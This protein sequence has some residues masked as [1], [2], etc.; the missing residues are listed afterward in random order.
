MSL[1]PGTQLGPYEISAPL[2]AGGMGEVYRARDTRLE[3]T[4]AIKILPAQFSSDPVR[5]QRFEREAK[6]I[7]S[8]NHPHICVLHDVGHQDGVDYLVM[9]CVEGETLAKRLEKG[10]LPLEQVLKYGAQI[11][12]ALDK[13]HRKGVVHRDLKPGNMMLTPSGAKLLD[14]GLARPAAPLTSVATMTAAVTQDSPV[15][16]QGTIVGTFQ[17][18][19]PE[20]VEGKEL[21]GR[22]DIFSLGAVLYEMLTGQR[23]FPGKSQLSVASAILEKEPAPISSI[24]P[25]APPV[26]D[27]AVKKCLA[28][29][30]ED[31]W[32]SAHD[33]KDELEW[34]SQTS[35]QA[36]VVHVP[37]RRQFSILVTGVV[38]V[39][40]GA[41]AA[42]IVLWNRQP[43]SLPRP[44]TRFAI[45]LPPRE[46][47]PLVTWPT[48]AS[49]PDGT[50][51][52]Y[53]AGRGE[54]RQL[55][56]RSMDRLE[57]TPLGGTENA[58]SPFFSPDGQW[59]GFFA[60][61]KLKK[62]NLRGGF[63]LTVCDATTDDRGGSWGPDDT[64]IFAPAAT[65]GLMRVPA[66][67]GTPQNLTTPDPGKRER[68]HRWPEILPGGK[69]VVFTIGS[70]DSIDYYLAAKIAVQ[71]LETGKREILPV[72]GTF[73]RYDPAGYIVLAQRGGLFAV[74]FD[75]KR[76]Q[77]TGT[78]LRVLDDVAMDASTGAIDFSL[79][80][81]GSLS[82]LPGGWYNADLVLAWVDRK[83]FVQPLPAPARAYINAHVSPD[84]KRVA[85][86]DQGGAS[87]GIWVYDIPRGTMMRL[88][89]SA[90]RSPLWTPD[91][92]HIAYMV[93]SNRTFA[94]KWKLADGSGPEETLLGAQNYTQ[95]PVSWSPDGKF[96]AYTSVGGPVFSGVR[97]WILPLEGK[98]EPQEFVK[99]GTTTGAARFSPNG[100]WIAYGSNE[101]GRSEVYVEPFPGPGGKWQISTEGG[102]WPVWARSG[103][104]LF[105]L[106][107]SK[108]MSVGVT[109]QPGFAAFTPRPLADVPVQTSSF[110]GAN[111]EFDVS[112]DDQHFLFIEAREQNALPGEVRVVLNWDEGL[113]HL[114]PSGKP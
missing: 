4:V 17:Y 47:A 81:T 110:Y 52:V 108:I 49:S 20:Q 7:S 26:L 40:I 9:E 66:S 27:H 59:I 101:S 96:L 41:L 46:T 98:R 83:G 53:V 73:A 13:A 89:Y 94:I 65:S 87:S 5:K 68:T 104:E 111:G 102:N 28:K 64:I 33:L 106:N 14:F 37:S 43:N 44:L 3:R 92:K 18:M 61:G 57:V 95:I 69:A 63:P 97:I 6:T 38:S 114:V 30:S 82:Y 15:T 36:A 34:I 70:L 107:G 78:P 31:R 55:Y 91:G 22:S 103:R 56:L 77:V 12:D 109:V 19:S 113:K 75:V 74:P 50:Q 8:L 88:T 11:A 100:H 79:S 45:T 62:V 105:Y 32:Q 24:K 21:D 54:S 10:P 71:S 51:L 90:D 35:S 112:P 60:D 84:G 25:M 80:R 23:A 93:E 48:V 2:G 76:L 42:A 58:S 85:V 1:A 67:G 16:E 99:T 29:D 39:V 86:S 72:E